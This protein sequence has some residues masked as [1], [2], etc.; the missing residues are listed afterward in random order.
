MSNE[1]CLLVDDDVLRVAT[2]IVHA[3][4]VRLAGGG[5]GRLGHGEPVAAEE[6]RCLGWPARV[7]SASTGAAHRHIA[8]THCPAP[9]SRGARAISP[10]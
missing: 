7:V 1:F 6:G 8:L 3:Q 4:T 2:C 5:C 10:A 9:S